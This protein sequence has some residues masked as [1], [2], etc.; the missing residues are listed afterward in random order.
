[1]FLFSNIN[2]K[3]KHL[4]FQPVFIINVI[5]QHKTPRPTGQT[6]E[7]LTILPRRGMKAYKSFISALKK[8]GNG[9]VADHL[10]AKDG[11]KR[12]EVHSDTSGIQDNVFSKPKD[13]NGDTQ[14]TTKQYAENPEKSKKLES[15]NIQGWP[16]L[17]NGLPSVKKRDIVKCTEDL[18]TQICKSKNG[19]VYHMTGKKKG[20]VLTISNVQCSDQ[21]KEAKAVNKCGSCVDFDKTSLSQLFTYMQ[22][23][24][25][26]SYTKR[27]VSEEDMKTFLA[28]QLE[29][30]DNSTFDSLVIVFYSGGMEF[31]PDC[32]YDTNGR[33]IDKD[34]ILEMIRQSK[35]FKDKPK[36]VIIRTY[37]F[38]EETET[39][40]VLDAVSHELHFY[41]RPNKDDLFVV[42][43]QPRTK[44]GPWIIGDRMNGSYFIQAI[45][46][47][48][49]KMA[50]EKSF[51]EMMFEVN[52]CLANASM[53]DK[54]TQAVAEVMVLEHSDE[55]EL[56]FYPGLKGL[57]M[58]V[59]EWPDLTAGASTVQ[60][61]DVII[62]EWD[63]YTKIKNEEIYS[64]RSANR[65][66]FILISNVQCIPCLDSQNE[67][68][69]REA[70]RCEERYSECIRNSDFDKSNM[71]QL[72]KYMGYDL[73]ADDQVENLTKEE[74]KKFLKTKLMDIDND[75]FSQYDSLALLFLSGEIKCEAAKIYDKEGVFIPRNEILDIV[76][77]CNHFK[78][79]PK[80]IFVQTY[81]FQ[82]K[83]E[84]FDQTDSTA[85]DIIKK[86]VP[87]TDDIF[88]VS[89]YP[90]IEQDPWIIG[91][92]M[93]GSYFI[94]ALVHV[95]KNF[96]YKKSFMELLKEANIC[97]N[98]TLIPK[99]TVDG[100]NSG[101]VER[102]PVAQI[103]LL[104]YSE[105]KE[106]YFFP[107]LEFEATVDKDVEPV[108][109]SN[110]MSGQPVTTA[111]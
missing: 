89:S 72:L 17:L 52:N 28:T 94:Q 109:L 9:E 42:S 15:E 18:R 46:H 44:N 93:I 90:R 24:T 100:K 1:M 8:T 75:A 13:T 101:T 98:Q 6:R 10:I 54:R 3:K 11:S 14:E 83:T 33:E 51:M 4:K 76:K 2:S 79:K 86:G 34:G 20:K 57:D 27:D 74:I 56:F 38:K 45:I 84:P 49:K 102:K 53:P 22:Y 105:E 88:M 35:Y 65:G 63:F 104:E 73:K 48:F 32:I 87:N 29:N 47:V 78:G 60:K 59:P 70:E 43:S 69:K 111:S 58:I 80:V 5:S 103:V 108:N 66:K 68:D 19:K 41:K 39:G 81:S 82:G 40:D 23:E 25:K 97:L 91:E 110:S 50:H 95:F 92:N 96:A 16:D 7:L 12:N 61:K 30:E 62:S 71:S 106:L 37:D 55:K 67:Q 85:N 26:Q 107:G 77:E 99:L 64:M 21:S 36:I 31:K